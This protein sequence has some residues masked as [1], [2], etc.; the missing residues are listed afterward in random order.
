MQKILLARLKIAK[1]LPVSGKI[2]T[3]TGHAVNYSAFP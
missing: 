1:F 3:G 2:R